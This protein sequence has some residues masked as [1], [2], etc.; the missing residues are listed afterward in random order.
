MRGSKYWGEVL[1]KGHHVPCSVSQTGLHPALV[2][3]PLKPFGYISHCNQS[4]SNLIYKF[5]GSGDSVIHTSRL[6]V[7]GYT[8]CL[9]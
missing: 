4:E 6:L 2:L 8:Y 5:Y 7:P 1:L 9:R 3:I